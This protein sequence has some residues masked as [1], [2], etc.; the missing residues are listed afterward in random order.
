MHACVEMQ[1]N[2]AG[3]LKQLT[4]SSGADRLTEAVAAEVLRLSKGALYAVTKAEFDIRMSAIRDKS[5]V[6]HDYLVTVRASCLRATH[7]L[8]A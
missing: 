5:Q 3:K 7:L 2:S 4:T 8:V 6:M 1:R